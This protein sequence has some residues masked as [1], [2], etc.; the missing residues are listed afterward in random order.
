MNYHKKMLG[1]RKMLDDGFNHAIYGKY[2]GGYTRGIRFKQSIKA[3]RR[4][5]KKWVKNR[6]LKQLTKDNNE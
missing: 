1:I 3:D 4:R 6:E 2:K 5:Q